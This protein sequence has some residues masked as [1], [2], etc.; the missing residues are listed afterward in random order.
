MSEN[1]A[2]ILTESAERGGDEVAM[3]LDDVELT[4]GLLDEGTKRLA[5]VLREK[6]L[7]SHLPVMCDFWELSCSAPGCT[8]ATHFRFIGS[9]TIGIRWAP[10]TSGDG[11]RC[12]RL[13]STR[14]TRG[15]SPNGRSYRPPGSPSRRSAAV[16]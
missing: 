7:E 11:S 16:C 9:S 1:L 6:G 10:T 13:L 12:G 5:G 3:K 2:T 15:R 8:A 14:C 4:Y